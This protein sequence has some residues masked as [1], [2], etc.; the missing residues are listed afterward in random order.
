MITGRLGWHCRYS[1]FDVVWGSYPGLSGKFR[2]EDLPKLIRV[3]PFAEGTAGK[4]E[5]SNFT[6]F[7]VVL[8]SE[9]T[10]YNLGLFLPKSGSFVGT[11][12]VK[13][14][15]LFTDSLSAV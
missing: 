12:I 3:S 6:F 2:L 5:T 13:L 11:E 1:P 9:L 15:D 7:I 4:K 8:S 14:L 10:T